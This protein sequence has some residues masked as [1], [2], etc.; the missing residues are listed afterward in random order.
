MAEEKQQIERKKELT[1]RG[2]TI[3]ELKQ[4]DIREFA[5]FIPSRERRTILR[6]TDYIENFLSKCRKKNGKNKQIKTHDRDLVIVPEMVDMII[7]VHNG[8]S[9]ERVMITIEMLG[10]RIGE[11]SLTRSHVKHGAAGIGATRSSA[12]RSVK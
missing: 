8:R 10:H 5:K 4:L 11:F 12:S 9:F 6:N 2:K 1:F 3:E 7:N